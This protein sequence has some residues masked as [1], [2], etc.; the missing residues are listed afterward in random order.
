[1]NRNSV[2]VIVD[3]HVLV[4]VD[5]LR[6]LFIR[7]PKSDHIRILVHVNDHVHGILW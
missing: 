7:D 5:G 3:V 1:M 2:D 6:L 4:D